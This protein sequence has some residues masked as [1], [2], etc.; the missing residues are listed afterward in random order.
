MGKIKTNVL[1]FRKT[2]WKSEIIDTVIDGTKIRQLII[3]AQN[4]KK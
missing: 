3:K 2:F 4:D 1:K